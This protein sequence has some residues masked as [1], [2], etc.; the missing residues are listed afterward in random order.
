MQTKRLFTY[1]NLLFLCMWLQVINKVKVIYQGQ[2]HTSR[3]RSNQCQ[4]QIK[5]VFK[6]RCFYTG[7]LH[8]NLMRSCWIMSSTH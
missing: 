2:G 3:L 6:E 4:G 5:V 8:L 1:F 7:G